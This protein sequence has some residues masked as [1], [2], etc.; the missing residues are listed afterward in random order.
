VA[1]ALPA[2]LALFLAAA[3]LG[4]RPAF[5]GVACGA[6]LTSDTVLER[7]LTDCPGDGLVI[8]AAGIT[9]D[10]NGHTV[11]GTRAD[12]SVGIRNER[13]DRVTIANGR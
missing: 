5:A 3:A 11:D 13:H 9:V 8:G 7:D 1:L 12:D 4:D 6:V 2:L 10:L